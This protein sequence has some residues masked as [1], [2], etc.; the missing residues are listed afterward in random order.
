MIYCTHLTVNDD[1]S[2]EYDEIYGYS[3]EGGNAGKRINLQI[4]KN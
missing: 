2:I 1:G 4:T 3:R